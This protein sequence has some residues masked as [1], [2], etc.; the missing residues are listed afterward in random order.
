MVCSAH[1]TLNGHNFFSRRAIAI[2]IADSD[3]PVY[4]GQF[5]PVCFLSTI[6]RMRQHVEWKNESK[7]GILWPNSFYKFVYILPMSASTNVHFYEC[8][9]HQDFKLCFKIKCTSFKYCYKI[10]KVFCRPSHYKYKWTWL[11]STKDKR[12]TICIHSLSFYHSHSVFIWMNSFVLPYSIKY[13]QA[14]IIRRFIN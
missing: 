2:R 12:G 4:W 1:F 5:L 10:F 13:W 9:P 7:S 6:V 11:A 14:N 3:F 8:P